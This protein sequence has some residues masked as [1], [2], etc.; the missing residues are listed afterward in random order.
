MGDVLRFGLVG[1]GA[2]GQTYLSVIAAN[3]AI[4]L[5]GVAD[6]RTA[7]AAAAAESAACTAY[8]D[9]AALIDDARPDGIVICVPPVDHFA[10]ANAAIEAGVAT[11]CEKP[12]CLTVPEAHTLRDTAEAKNAL[13]TMASKFRYVDDV[14]RGK[15]II[16]SGILGDIIIL[17]NVFT[18]RVDM[19]NRWNADPAV[20]GGGVLIDNGTHAVDIVRYLIG[21]VAEVNAMT[22]RHVQ[23]L[24]VEDT[25]TLNIRTACGVDAR[26]ELSWSYHNPEDS[27]VAVYGTRG[28]LCIGWSRSRYKRHEDAEW[29]TFGNGYDKQAA[30]AAQIGNFCAAMTGN[31]TLLIDNNDAVASVEVIDAAYESLRIGGW[32]DV[33]DHVRNIG[34]TERSTEK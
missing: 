18:G 22:G 6:N 34:S 21:P 7:V 24:A 4:D 27:F 31:E 32:I 13:F 16:S 9:A 1:A 20:S 25:A 33:Q 30:F 5:V 29:V 28:T 10:I 17:E 19:S 11:L 12:L 8:P 23:N 26:V 15:A 3:S 14:V 2:I